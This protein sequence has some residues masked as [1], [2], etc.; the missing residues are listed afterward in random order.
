MEGNNNNEVD[1]IELVYKIIVFF[2]KR[3]WWFVCFALLGAVFGS[4]KAFT[5]KDYYDSSLLAKTNIVS[6]EIVNGI[7]NQ[8]SKLSEQGDYEKIAQ[9]LK[10]SEEQVRE[11]RSLEVSAQEKGNVL[12]IHI[13]VYNEE[14]L[15]VIQ[16]ALI[17]YVDS[18]PFIKEELELLRLQNNSMIEKIDEEI[19]YLSSLKK[20]S[21]TINK[22]EKQ[23]FVYLPDAQSLISKKMLELYDEKQKKEKELA[24]KEHAV[25]MITNFQKEKA[26]ANRRI[27]Q[28]FINMLLFLF[29]GVFIVSIVSLFKGCCA[30]NKIK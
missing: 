22:D 19:E 24:A 17:R 11:L 29:V 30:Y 23:V 5:E 28:I 7:L 4:V 12:D 26:P 15:P 3:L 9:D 14:V 18:T 1:L 10:I 13:Q 21:K 6:S 25:V 20:S 8:L 16:D 27:S 2:K